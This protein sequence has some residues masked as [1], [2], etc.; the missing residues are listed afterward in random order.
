MIITVTNTKTSRRKSGTGNLNHC[1]E[2]ETWGLNYFTFGADFFFYVKACLWKIKWEQNWS[3]TI[4]H[5]WSEQST[6]SL[7]SGLKT[8]HTK[9]QRPQVK[10]GDLWWRTNW[11]IINNSQLRLDFSW[12]TTINMNYLVQLEDI[13]GQLQHPSNHIKPDQFT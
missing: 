6:S 5:L 8:E 9:L 12:N 3:Y 2:L 11:I 7:F 13:P 1:S 4:T 10:W